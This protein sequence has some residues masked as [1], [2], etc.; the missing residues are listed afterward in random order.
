MKPHHFQVLLSGA[1]LAASVMNDTARADKWTQDAAALKTNFNKVLWVEEEGM[2]RDNETSSLIPQDGN[3]LAVFFNLTETF[4]QKE[5]ISK[6]L[7]RNW[8]ELG[9]VGPELPDTVAPFVSGFEVC[10]C[11]IVWSRSP[12]NR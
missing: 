4:A 10:P 2:Y 8:V 3:S 5:S 11:F 7:T 12:D 6:G 9:A 1:E